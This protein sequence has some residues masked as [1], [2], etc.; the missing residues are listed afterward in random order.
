LS[1]TAKTIGTI[2]AIVAVAAAVAIVIVGTGGAATPFLGTTLGTIMAGASAVSAIASSIAVATAKPPDAQGSINQVIIGRNMP[3]PYAIGRTYAGGF[4]VYDNSNGDNNRDRSQIMVLSAAGPIEGFEA[5]QADFTTIA[6]NTSAGVLISGEAVG[7]YNNH[8]YADTRLGLRPDSA[9]TGPPGRAPLRGWDAT[10]KLSG[11]AAFRM[12]MKFDKEAERFSSGVPQFGAV[13]KGPR[14]YDPRL[15]STYPGGAGACRWNDEATFVYGAAPYPSAENP[16][17][18]ALN[19]A[20]GRYIEKTAG[21]APLATPVK[22]LGCG[23]DF[24]EIEVAQFVELANICDANGWQAGGSIYEA[25]GSSKWENLKRILAACAAQPTWGGGKLGVKISAP[26]TSVVTIGLPD[27]A[28]GEVSVQA[29]KSFRDKLNTIVPRVR[30]EAHRWEYTQLDEVTNAT[31]LAE[32]GGEPKSKETQFDLVQRADQGAELAAYELVN[33]REFGPITLPLKPNFMV[34]QIGEAVTV[35]VPELGLENQLAIILSRQIDPSNGSVLF[36]LES[37]TTAK[38][39]FALG[40]TGVAPPSPTI[41][42]PQE[43]DETTG[44]LQGTQ[45]ATTALI[46]SSSPSDLTLSID[47][48]GTI[49]VSNHNRVYADKVVAVTGA[50]L[51]PVPGAGVWPDM[52][53][54]FYDDQFRAGGAVGYH[55]SVIVGGIGET[56]HLFASAAAPWRHFVALMQVPQAGS[57]PS[58]GGSGTGPDSG[59][60]GPPGGGYIPKGDEE[61]P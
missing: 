37:E 61:W 25:P 31:Y 58:S 52:V 22:L 56:G 24:A 33:G 28:D 39:D 35:N 32:D 1:K 40:R 50:T 10:H 54:V 15:D 29:M 5:L 38:H 46:L 34:Y 49:I 59:G 4:Q 57:P 23:F 27:L 7:Y 16:A 55:Y 48:A 8:L 13:F 3:V 21:G 19:Y 6:F 11:Y 9:F 17:I 20:R 44:D 51:A 42:P 43:M 45:A 26:R 36:T 41:R 53:G 30:L 14:V 2:A 12:T 18:A 47:T 60:T